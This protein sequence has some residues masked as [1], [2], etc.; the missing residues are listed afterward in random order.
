MSRINQMQEISSFVKCIVIQNE[1]GSKGES[2]NISNIPSVT[3]IEM[4]FDAFSD[5]ALMKF[6]SDNDE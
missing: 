2:F 6:E 4:R 5:C 1:A 3:C